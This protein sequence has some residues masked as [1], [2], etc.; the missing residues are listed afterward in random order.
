MSTHSIST[1]G[2]RLSAQLVRVRALMADHRW[3][4]L[5]EI[6]D[7]VAGSEAGVSARLRELRKLKFGGF[8]VERRRVSLGLYE[9]RVLP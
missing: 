4:T 1:D 8:T 5:A 9:Y 3:R 7:A 6:A 2:E